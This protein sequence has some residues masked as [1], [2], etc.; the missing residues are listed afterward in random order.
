MRKKIVAGNWKMNL[1][2][3]E[4]ESLVKDIIAKLPSVSEPNQVIFCS[5]FIHIERISNILKSANH[6]A[7]HAGAQNCNDHASGAY[8]G[9]I[10]VSMLKEVGADTVIIGHSERRQYFNESNELL[11]SKV[12]FLIANQMHILFCCGEPL[13]IRE[14]NQ[15]NTYVETQL[16]ESLFHLTADQLKGHISIAYEPIWAIGTGVTAS[17]AQAQDMHAYIR[18]LLVGKYGKETANEISIL[19]GGSCNASNAKELFDCEDVD[20]GLIGGAALKVETFVPIIEAMN[21]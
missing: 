4:G 21:S 12:D 15:Q 2:L 19:Y 10:S 8:T 5:P 1:S 20:G 13:S 17:T 14:T 3:V 7:L 9:E 6:D 11:K 16:N 18:S